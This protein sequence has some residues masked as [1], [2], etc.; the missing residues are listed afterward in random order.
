MAL[1]ILK[2]VIMQQNTWACILFSFPIINMG[3]R[4][5]DIAFSDIKDREIA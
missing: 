5:I 1:S 3:I 4:D 2:I